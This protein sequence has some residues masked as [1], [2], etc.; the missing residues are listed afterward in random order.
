MK[1]LVVVLFAVLMITTGCDNRA[2]NQSSEYDQTQ[3]NSSMLSVKAAAIPTWERGVIYLGGDQVN[4][5]NK[6]WEAKWWTTNEEPG[7]TGQWGVWKEV[8][9]PVILPS[10]EISAN[11]VSV[12]EGA[13]ATLTWSSA[14]ATTVV[15]SGGWTGAKAFSGSEITLPL[16]ATTEFII[17]ASDGKGNSDVK[18]VTVT[19]EKVVP[20][21][22]LTAT[23]ETVL[24]GQQATLT[25]NVQN[26]NSVVASDGW[27]GNKT[28]SGTET[29]AALTTSTK[30]TLTATD[31]SGNAVVKSVV[32]KVSTEIPELQVGQSRILTDAQILERY[33]GIDAAYLPN[34]VAANVSSLMNQAAY[35]ELFP[36]RFGTAL[37][38]ETSGKTAPDYYSYQNICDALTDIAR[39]KVRVETKNYAQRVFRLEKATKTETLLRQDGDYTADWLK[40][41]IPKVEVVDYG[42]FVGEGSLE[43]RKRNLAAF[44]ANI[45]HETTGGWATAPGGAQAWGLYFNEEVGCD[46]NTVGRYT[47]GG[48]IF[49][50]PNTSES[51]H[52]RGPMQL[53]WNYNYGF[54]SQIIYGDKSILLNNPDS[55]TKDGK[56]GFMTAIW[57]WMT[58]QSP[59]PACHDVMSGNWVPTAADIAANRLPGFGVTVNVINGGLEAGRPNDYRVVDRIEFFKKTTAAFGVTVGQNVDCYTQSP[60]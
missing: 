34:A 25:W 41:V 55:V 12:K 11:P 8:E 52:G 42:K 56:L 32:V 57:F 29:T 19:V 31:A 26:A 45:A 9:N 18:S 14:N 10:V 6:V 20:V 49:Y 24:S 30:Y 33:N 1:K 23:P 40:N 51:Y 13:T 2:E 46:D 27:I 3:T 38:S 53:S 21:I 60:F 39:L 50:P 43:T 36:R 35:E 5:N 16:N 4:W 58:P 54:M 22:T 59:K 17:T 44:L 28:M 37:W 15:A 48:N 7:T 47:D